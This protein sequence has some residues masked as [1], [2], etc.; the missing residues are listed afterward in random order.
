MPLID[1]LNLGKAARTQMNVNI[2]IKL[3][4]KTIYR[5]YKEIKSYYLKVTI[6]LKISSTK[7][8]IKII[9]V[10]RNEE[11]SKA[12]TSIFKLYPLLIQLRFR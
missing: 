10:F 3:L 2:K 6:H 1:H 4:K 7:K 8:D 9:L 12:H 5:W 11:K